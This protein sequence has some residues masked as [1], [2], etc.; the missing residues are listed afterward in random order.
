MD[1]TNQKAGL[2]LNDLFVHYFIVK[3]KEKSL[4][5]KWMSE[6]HGIKNEMG[7]SGRID[8]YLDREEVERQEN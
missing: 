1:K 6:R 7:E 5:S 3:L 2:I 4:A 8:K